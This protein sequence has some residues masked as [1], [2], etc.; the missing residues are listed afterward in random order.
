MKM[1][2]EKIK[3]M[4]EKVMATATKVYETKIYQYWI[5]EDGRLCRAYLSDLDTMAMYEPGAIEILD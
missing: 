1:S 4:H 2:S 3:A 5:N